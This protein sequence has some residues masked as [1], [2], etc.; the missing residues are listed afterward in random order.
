MLQGGLD[1]I[2]GT[3]DAHLHRPPETAEGSALWEAIL[4]ANPFIWAP[5]ANQSAAPLAKSLEF[6][7]FPS[8]SS[9]MSILLRGVYTYICIYI[10]IYMCVCMCA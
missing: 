6:E 4:V 9:Y 3:R 8:A 7:A 2:F 10:Y 1:P 5:A